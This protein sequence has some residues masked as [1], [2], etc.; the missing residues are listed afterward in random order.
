MNATDAQEK[1]QECINAVEYW[2][3]ENKLKVNATKTEVMLFGTPQKIAGLSENNFCIKFGDVTLKIVKEFKYL[4]MHLDQNL[5]WN[6][7]CEN[8]ASKA[9]LKLQIMRRLQKILPKVTMIQIYKT[10]MMPVLEYAATVWGYTTAENI[11][12]VQRIINLCARIVCNNYDFINCRGADLLKEL[13]WNTFEERRDFLLSV[14]MYKCHEGLAPAYL[15]DKLN[16]H[17]ELNLRPSRHTD[18]ATYNIQRTRTK[19]AETAM[20]IKGPTIWNKLPA[21]IRNAASLNQFKKMYK[22]DILMKTTDFG[23]THMASATRPN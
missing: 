23:M 13:G 21:N 5:T 19:K 7:H 15:M 1:L 12:R 14:L 10:Y 16:L 17:S 22:K 6:K 4:G 2:Y 20:T 8:I 18:E 11:N 3:T 9:G